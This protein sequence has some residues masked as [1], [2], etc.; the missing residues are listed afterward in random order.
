[1]LTVNE[2][3]AATNEIGPLAPIWFSVIRAEYWT[4]SYRSRRQIMFERRRRGKVTDVLPPLSGQD[5]GWGISNHASMSLS[6]FADVK[7]V[8]TYDLQV[9]IIGFSGGGGRTYAVDEASGLVDQ[10][11]VDSLGVETAVALHLRSRV[12]P[13]RRIDYT[14][15]LH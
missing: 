8:A 9:S 6:R 13:C 12:R 14:K 2:G 5:C 3:L 1:M 7:P 10:V 15:S 11:D 4:L